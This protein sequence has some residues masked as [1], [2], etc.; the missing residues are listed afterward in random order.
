MIFIQA[1][2]NY[3]W[4]P[5]FYT[6]KYTTGVCHKDGHLPQV[7]NELVGLTAA[8]EVI[9]SLQTR[10]IHNSTSISQDGIS[11]SASGL[12]PKT[13]QPRIDELE[14]RREKILRKVKSKFNQ[15]YYLSNI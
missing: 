12:G 11:Q 8:I 2:N 3:R 7:I 5:A 15:K 9:S 10:F 13:F 1:V 14:K 4:L 6:I